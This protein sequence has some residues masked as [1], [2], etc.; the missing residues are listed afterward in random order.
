MGVDQILAL[1]AGGLAVVSLFPQAEKWPLLSVAVLL[2]SIAV[3]LP[4]R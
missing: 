1:I 4:G 2:V 3:F